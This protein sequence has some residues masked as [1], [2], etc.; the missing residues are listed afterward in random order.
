MENETMDAGILNIG[1]VESS[2]TIE[3]HEPY[4]PSGSIWSA[5]KL[6]IGFDNLP[7]T[8]IIN[9]NIKYKYNEDLIL[10][11]LRSYIDKTYGSHYGDKVQ[12]QDLIVSSG[13]GEGFY[14]GNII[15]YASRYGKK[16]G[17]NKDD[18]LK[19]LHYAVLAMNH[20]IL[21]HEKD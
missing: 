12:A 13:H 7:N 17:H 11:E 20:H 18:L 9:K 21:N 8:I 19:V 14:L 15:K 3:N 16:N 6:A 10:A 4:E 5:E 1:I 2:L